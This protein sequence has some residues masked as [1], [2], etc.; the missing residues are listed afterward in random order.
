MEITEVRVFLKD[1]DD[2]KLKAYVTI[3]FDDSFVVRDL[4][5]ID[6]NRGLF[7]AMPSRKAKENCAQC[8]HKNVVRSRYCSQCGVM[9]PHKENVEYDY[10]AEH[11]DIAHPIT[12]DAREYVQ[13]RVLDAFAEEI[14][15]RASL[16]E[17]ASMNH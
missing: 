13:G 5:I 11:R 1:S 6:G 14:S 2:K 8:S 4:K 10:Q 7:V 9:L 12:V 3:T 15:K 16:G 17:V